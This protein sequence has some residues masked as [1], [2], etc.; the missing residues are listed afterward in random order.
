ML[1]GVPFV[2]SEL[3]MFSSLKNP[4]F[5]W[6]WVGMLGSF[7]AMQMQM[8]AQGWLVYTMTNSPLAL[9]IVSAGWGLPVL[10]FSLLGGAVTDRV[11]K[12]NL[13]MV[14]QSTAGIIALTVA[15]LVASGSVQLWHLIA[16]SL[17]VGVV[18]SF[19]MPGR[20]AIIPELVEESNLM[21]AIALNSAAMNLMRIGAP[22]LGGVL[23][24]VIGVAGVYFLTVASYAFVV[25]TLLMIRNSGDRAPQQQMSL[26]RSMMEGLRY[27][28]GN[29]ILAVLLAMALIPILFA[30][31]YQMLM[32]AFAVGVLH[33]GP[34]GLGILMAATGVG[35]L[36]GSLFIA[37][38]GNFQRKGM[39]LF[40]AALV[41]GL[42]LLFLGFSQSFGLSLFILLLTGAGGTSYMAVNNT[43]LQTNVTHEVR[44][45]V[46]SI[47]M[48]T[49][50]LM[51]LGA[52]PASALAEAWGVSF[53]LGL[54]GGIMAFFTL[55]FALL[56]PRMRRLE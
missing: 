3:Q 9:G 5:R 19:N 48:M 25:G 20:Q 18:F 29:Y 13:L 7:S 35:A 46:M 37:S 51:P 50:G 34:E 31:P 23:I 56:F 33:T 47:Y 8:I 32:P 27:I 41:F 11:N 10:V 14:T 16:A 40:G 15:I 1:S 44:G 52:L 38:L 26:G 24:G 22:A 49:W 21:N 12:R 55:A 39:L 53:A 42:A 6:Y 36:L 45:R 43:L 54:G 4:D 30:M 17:A 2:L 28:R